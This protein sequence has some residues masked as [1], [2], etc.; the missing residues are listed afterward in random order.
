MSHHK[1][2]IAGAKPILRYVQPLI[3]SGAH[4]ASMPQANNIIYSAPHMNIK[5]YTIAAGYIVY[6]EPRAY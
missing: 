3:T 6:I 4:S 5:L 2:C 1:A